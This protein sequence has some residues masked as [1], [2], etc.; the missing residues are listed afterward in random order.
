MRGAFTHP[1]HS[2]EVWAPVES[3]RPILH[4]TIVPQAIAFGRSE[5]NANSARKT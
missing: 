3:F 5:R 1:D 4:G 2:L